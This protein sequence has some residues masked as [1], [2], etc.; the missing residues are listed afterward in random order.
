MKRKG[1]K[2]K[3]VSSTGNSQKCVQK[4]LSEKKRFDNSS[5]MIGSL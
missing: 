3:I 1:E 4:D 5:N 2:I